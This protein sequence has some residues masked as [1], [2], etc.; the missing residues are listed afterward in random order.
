MLAKIDICFKRYNVTTHTVT[1]FS[2]EFLLTGVKTWGNYA[3]N[4][5]LYQSQEKALGNNQRNHEIN[6]KL[7]KDI[8][9]Y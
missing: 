4:I 6:E 7:S 3:Q 2:L 8:K 9:H 5:T 1:Q